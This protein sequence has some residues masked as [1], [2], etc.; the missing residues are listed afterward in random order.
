MKEKK[1]EVRRSST[2]CGKEA[3]IKSD[4]AARV[5]GG[6]QVRSLAFTLASSEWFM[7]FQWEF[8]AC[9]SLQWV[10]EAYWDIRSYVSKISHFLFIH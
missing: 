6:I 4:I 9:C 3:Q 5:E 1:H 10:R 8:H 7:L 2:Q